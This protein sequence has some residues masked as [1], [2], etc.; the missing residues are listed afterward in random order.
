MKSRRRSCS[1]TRKQ[2]HYEPL[3]VNG[4]YA[5]PMYSNRWYYVLSKD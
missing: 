3:Y 1:S 5:N 2:R 4:Y